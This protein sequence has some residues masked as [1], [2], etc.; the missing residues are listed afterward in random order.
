[1]AAELWNVVKLQLVTSCGPPSK[2]ASRRASNQ[3]LNNSGLGD[4]RTNVFSFE[5][6]QGKEL[7][8][9]VPVCFQARRTS[10]A[11]KRD[12]AKTS[13]TF[14]GPLL[15]AVNEASFQTRRSKTAAQEIT[16][17]LLHVTRQPVSKF[18][19]TAYVSV[20]AIQNRPA[21]R[22]PRSYCSYCAE[23]HVPDK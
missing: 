18:F 20:T 23:Q 10:P 13:K 3:D 14:P 17:W 1:M 2:V 16:T 6:R 19:Q 15:N 9:N 21:G 8:E 5:T 12:R 22:F 7:R 11:L 4:R